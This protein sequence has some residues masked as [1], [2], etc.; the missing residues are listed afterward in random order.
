VIEGGRSPVG[1]GVAQRAVG[2]EATGHVRRVSGAGK[3]GLVA[4]IAVGR[5]CQVIVIHVALRARHGDVC[6]GQRERRGVVIERGTCPVGG[7]VAHGTRSGQT[8]GRVR[9]IVG[10]VVIGLM[11]GI[12]VSRNGGVVVVD[13][14]RGAS[15]RSM[16]ARQRKHRSMIKGRGRPRRGGVAQSAIGRETRSYVIRIGSP[17][18][19]LGVARIAIG[20][21]G[22][23]VIVD[24]ACSAG[25]R[26]VRAGQRE[27]RGVVIERGSRP[28]GGAVANRA[29]R[30]Q[31]A[32]RMGRGIGAV[33][34]LC[35]AGVTVGGQAAGVIAIDV[36]RGAGHSGVRAGQRERR[37]VVIEGRRSPVGGRMADRA[38]GWEASCNVR[39]IGGASEV[40]LVAAIA[41]RRQGRV[42]VI[43]VARSAGHR[44][45]RTGEREGSLAVVEHGAI[46][47]RG[48]VANLTIGREAD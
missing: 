28:V 31:T 16:G 21:K 29:R 10:S 19:I 30:G 33:V 1:R 38:I 42:V 22:G 24:V 43:D 23:V 15:D 3:V 14:A 35:V 34:I 8:R 4:S 40:L 25:H 45:V 11:A 44:G 9:R 12:A 47:V 36:A 2:R 48:G 7:A 6:A 27:R 18:E 13:V 39:R 46:P 20:R 41:G 5:Q 37:R 32:G 17:G 26:D